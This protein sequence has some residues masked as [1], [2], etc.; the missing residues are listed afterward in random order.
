MAG[1][2]LLVVSNTD[3]PYGDSSGDMAK[4]VKKKEANIFTE[5]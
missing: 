1:R 4:D 2:F 3:A 5:A